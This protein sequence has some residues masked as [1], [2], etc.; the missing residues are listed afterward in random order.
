M[1]LPDKMNAVFLT[2]HGGFENL[3]YTSEAPLPSP[4][5]DEVLIKVL[6]AGMNTIDINTR[7]GQYSKET[8]VDTHNSSGEDITENDGES[9]STLISFPIIQG[10]D[11]CG[12]IVGVG[13]NIDKARIGERVL[14]RSMLPNSTNCEPYQCTTLGLKRNGAFAQ[15]T[16]AHAKDT[17][18]V[19]CDWGNAELASTPC[20][21]SSAESML[22]RASVGEETVL[23]NG[24]ARG[25]GC[26]TIQLCKRRGAHVIAIA[27]K[28]KLSS[29]AG[30]GADEVIEHG[31][32]LISMIGENSVDVVIDV[33]PDDQLA[34]L[35]KVLKHDGRYVSTS[36]IANLA[37]ETHTPILHLKD[38]K[39]FDGT[40]QEATA[41]ENLI[42]Y[43]ET[44]EIKP[45][46]AKSYAL[47]DIVAAQQDFLD[48]KYVG[49]LVIV[50]SHD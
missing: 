49:K 4:S 15:Y 47:R 29:V 14:V 40:N 44:G 18:A 16:T 35:L 17:Y 2:G 8:E 12:L 25:I 45:L 36:P 38:L 26:A 23:I 41:F 20:S 7:T 42:S 5:P 1:S 30:I 13:E 19:N 27:N 6:A 28:D 39:F 48:K 10:V 46:V 31:A 24:G 32:D 21:Y 43:I 11:C 9:T 50:P 34:S 37:D 3:E 22:Q 33:I